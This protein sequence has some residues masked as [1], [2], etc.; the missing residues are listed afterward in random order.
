MADG[1][2]ILQVFS[3]KKGNIQTHFKTLPG[4]RITS[5]QLGGA[6]GKRQSLFTFTFR[7]DYIFC[8]NIT[9]L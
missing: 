3:I 8:R 6:A 1:D 5:V 9:R 7:I 2:G 4:T